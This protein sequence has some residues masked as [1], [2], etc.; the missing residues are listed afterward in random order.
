MPRASKRRRVSEDVDGD[1]DMG[2]DDQ[3]VFSVPTSPDNHGISP[4]PVKSASRRQTTRGD[5]PDPVT[6]GQGGEVEEDEAQTPARIGTRSS[7]RQ[8][9]TPKRYDQEAVTPSSRRKQAATPSRSAR[10]TRSAQKLRQS[11]V[12]DEEEDEPEFKEEDDDDDDMDLDEPSPEPAPRTITRTRSKRSTA[13][14]RSKKAL[15]AEPKEKS[16]S[17]GYQDGL[18]DIDTIQLQQDLYHDQ[19]EA[20]ET[21]DVSEPLPEYAGKF[22][23][24]CQTG[25]G[26]EMRI[27]STILLEKL[28][29]KRQIPVRGLEAEYQKV[30]QLIEQTVSIGEGNSML[31]LGSRGCGK[32]AI[33]ESIISSLRKEHCNEFHV[34]RLNGF[35][36]TDDR[37]ALREMWRQLGRETHT[38]EDAAKVSSYADTMATLLALLSHPEELFG[39]SG[40]PG[41]KTAAKSIVI[42]LDEFDLFVT[43]PRQTL[44]YNLFDIAQARKAP[45]TVIGLTTKVDVTEML[46]KR[47]KS[48]FSHRYTYVPLPRSFEAFSDICL[49]S[50]DLSDAE[51]VDIA[52]E[53]G[54]ERILVESNKWNTLLGGWKEYLKHLWNDNEFQFH[55]K[56][57]YNQTKSAK[58]FFNS[59]LL[60]IGDLLQSVST[61]DAPIPE[62]PTPKSFSSQS[63]ECPD[64][65]PLPFSTS[66]TSSSPSSLPLAL[67]VA[68]TRLA[69]L[70]DPGNDGSQSQSMGPLAL[71]FPAAYAEYVR[72]LT[73]AKV[74]ASVSGA[75][76]T[77]GRVW[78][79]DVARESWER[80]LS[81]GLVTPVGSGNGT[82]D[83][84]MFRVEIS[85]EEVIEMAGS[86]GALGQ[87]WR[88]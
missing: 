88:G 50:L 66:I 25:L 17:P 56:R 38:E 20:H 10:P 16:P 15:V 59:A 33:V 87:W 5:N 85:F 2:N 34:V 36:H 55:L 68:A 78:G 86:G 67:L 54:S 22:Q 27:L 46:E 60:P 53:L 41:S 7:G 61:A 47:V 23:A 26:D 3:D 80:L 35:L 29:G 76:A 24:L 14:P 45:I 74:S 64:P 1:I 48:R 43:H 18:D 42:L 9:K 81:W 13:K 8:R 30:H 31:L 11:P 79:R 49:G 4:T 21:I 83:G 72:L 37:L 40:D 44:L 39:T 63:L 57:I 69:A 62:V 65:A 84:Q 51:M 77:P 70:F 6:T 32:T 58:E 73:S 75:S 12:E 82:A 28:T 71:S 19:P 52:D